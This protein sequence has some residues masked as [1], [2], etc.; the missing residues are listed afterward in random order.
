MEKLNLEIKDMAKKINVRG[1]ASTTRVTQDYFR[2]LT[3]EQVVNLYKTYK[4]DFELFDYSI[5]PYLSLSKE[6]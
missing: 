3:K 4:P 6:D 1:G 5:E 2:K